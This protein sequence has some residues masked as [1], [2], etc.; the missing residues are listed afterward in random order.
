MDSYGL[1]ERPNELISKNTT[2]FLVATFC[3]FMLLTLSD[4]CDLVLLLDHWLASLF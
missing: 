4:F 3:F 1:S 2:F